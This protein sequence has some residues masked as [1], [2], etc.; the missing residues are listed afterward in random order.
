ML[1]PQFDDRYYYV[2]LA[3]NFL[4]IN[5]LTTDVG[6]RCCVTPIHPIKGVQ[7]IRYIANLYPDCKLPLLFVVPESIAAK[8]KK[9]PILTDQGEVP[10]HLPRVLQSVA[11]LPLGISTP[12]KIRFMKQ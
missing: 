1:H 12:A 9:Q 11:G 3:T 2:P 8:F 5:A 6:L 10:M 4:A 7:A